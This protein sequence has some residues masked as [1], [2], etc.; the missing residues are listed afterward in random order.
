MANF[1]AGGNDS[2]KSFNFISGRNRNF[3]G[4]PGFEPKFKITISRKIILAFAVVIILTCGLN[5]YFMAN[6]DKYNKQYES[7]LKVISTANSI[8]GVLKQQ[9]D[10]EMTAIV[11]GQKKFEDG[12]QYEILQDINDKIDLIYGITTSV[13]GKNDLETVK[14]TMSSLKSKV[15][16][17]G[18][19]IKEKKS[20]EENMESLDELNSISQLVEENIQSYI[21]SELKDSEQIK[22]RIKGDFNRA[23]AINAAALCIVIL[24]SVTLSWLI[25]SNISRPINKLREISSEIA[26]GNLNIDKIQ[27]NTR[28]EIMELAISFNE[29]IAGLKDIIGKVHDVSGELASASEVL[30]KSTEQSSMAIEEIAVSSQRMTQGIN[31]QNDETQQIENDIASISDAF[32]C[33]AQSSDKILDSAGQSVRLAVEGDEHI[34]NFI[35]QMNSATSDIT[36]AADDIRKL[37][38][39]AGEMN[40]IVKT[41]GDI[42]SQT[43]LLALNASIEAARAGEAGKGFAVV[44]QEIR[45]LAEKSASSAKRIGDI[46]DAVQNGLNLTS[47]KMQN[48]VEQILKGK[49]TAEK[50]KEYFDLIKQA[51]LVVDGDIKS[52][53]GEIINMRKIVEKVYGSMAKIQQISSRNVIEGE[54]ISASVQEQ[55]ANMEEVSSFASV[56]SELSKEM[57]KSIRKFKLS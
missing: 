11:N 39:S 47:D 38:I 28:D 27:I 16:S 9:I 46:I 42:S 40:G 49:Q 2:M 55:T 23:L 52:I 48:T 51:N 25:S 31:S 44:A 34:N 33:L 22:S 24:I 43:N 36:E 15:D 7:V 10:S 20:Y 17:I 19:Q 18:K 8:N 4:R 45:K 37:N 57:E 53:S 54:T 21:R 56:L 1:K 5:A 41:I 30:L 50:A 13:A 29:M 6:L 3:I 35:V 12:A 14:R 32:S 26:S